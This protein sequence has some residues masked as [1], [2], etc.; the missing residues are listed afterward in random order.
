MPAIDPEVEE[1]IEENI[2]I[3]YL[4]APVG[5]ITENG[6]AVA[7]KCLRMELGEPDESGRRRPVPIEGSE[8]EVPCSALIPAVSQEPEWRDAKRY[9]ND[10]DWFKPG[11]DWT[12]DEK[13]FVGGDAVKLGLACNAIG[14]GRKA[15]ENIHRLFSGEKSSKDDRKLTSANQLS[16]EYYDPNARSERS[17]L[18]P[19]D[20]LK[21][22]LDLEIDQG[23]SEEQFQNE[24][25]RCMSCGLCFECY[26]CMLYCPQVAITRFKENPAGEVMFTEY[27]KCVGCHICAEVCPCNYIQM[28]MSD[29]L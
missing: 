15:A 25:K 10:K 6:K 16:L 17:Y 2:E 14:D 22:G 20:R 5:I 29:E 11:K 7:L 9:V 1:A 19:V 28:G 21:G 3:L 12:V 26:E 8:F 18:P 4:T 24:A 23:I 13:V 27:N